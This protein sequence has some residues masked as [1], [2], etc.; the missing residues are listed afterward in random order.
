ML[1]LVNNNKKKK[2]YNMTSYNMTF[3]WWTKI[4]QIL[5]SSEA[6]YN[7][8]DYTAEVDQL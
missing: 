3:I 8:H 5:T 2:S 1:V 4:F 7:I 6:A